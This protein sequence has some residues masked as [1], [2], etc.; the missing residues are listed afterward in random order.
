M[1]H[2]RQQYGEPPQ[3]SLG[4]RAIESSTNL[5]SVIFAHFYFPTHSNGLKDVAKILGFR[6]SDPMAS[7]MRSV[8]VRSGWEQFCEP[9]AKEWL[10]RYNANDCEALEIVASS[11]LRTY[12][13]PRANESNISE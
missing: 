6:W 4:H 2:M 10:V 3:D 1:R 13:H 8:V 5:V 7:G 9:T 11:V 12:G